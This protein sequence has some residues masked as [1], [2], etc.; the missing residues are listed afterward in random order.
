M[1][2]DNYRIGYLLHVFFLLDLIVHNHVAK[3]KGLENMSL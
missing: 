2:D 1:E 3:I